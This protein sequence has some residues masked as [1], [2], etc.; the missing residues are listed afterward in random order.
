MNRILTITLLLCICALASPIPLLERTEIG[1]FTLEET[2][3]TKTCQLPALKLKP[4]FVP[5][6]RCRMAIKGKHAAGCNYGVRLSCNGVELT[7]KTASG[8]NRLLERQSRFELKDPQYKGRRFSVFRGSDLLM[9]FAPSTDA[10]DPVTVEGN[11]SWFCLDLSDLNRDVDCNTITFRNIR[12]KDATDRVIIVTDA[13]FGYRKQNMNETDVRIVNYTPSTTFLK[14]ATLRL[15]LY[16]GGAF[17]LSHNDK[18]PAIIIETAIGTTP[19]PAATLTATATPDAKHPAPKITQMGADAFRIQAT[20]GTLKME[21]TLRLLADRL[22]WKEKWSNQ[23]RHIAGVPFRHQCTLASEAPR[24]WLRGEPDTTDQLTLDGNATVFLESRK[25]PGAGAGIVLEDDILR[26]V[27]GA[28][29]EKGIA[30]IYSTTLAVAPGTS[31]SFTYS[32]SPVAEG[33]YWTFINE[34]RDRWGAGKFGIERPVFWA[35]HLRQGDTAAG[36]RRELGHLGNIAVSIPI[37]LPQNW[38]KPLLRSE[39]NVT[40][41]ELMANRKVHFQEFLERTIPKFKRALPNAKILT[42]TH[43][44]MFY[45]YL[46][47]FE[48]S[49]MAADA[50]RTPKGTPYRHDGFESI[51]LRNGVKKGWFIAYLLPRPGG[52][53]FQSHMATTDAVLAAGAD[54]LYCDEFS[55]CNERRSYSRYDYAEWDGFSADLD[56]NGNVIRLKSDCAYTSLQFQNALLHKLTSNGKFFLGNGPTVS[57]DILASAGHRFSEGASSHANM[58]AGHLNHVPL[59]LGNYGDQKSTAGVMAAVREA[60][61]A[62]CVYSPFSTTHFHLQGPDNFVCKL[63]PLTIHRLGPGTIWGKERLITCISGEYTLPP[64]AFAPRLFIY[65]KKGERVDAPAPQGNR[66]TLD[67]PEGGLVIVEWT[68]N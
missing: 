18:G 7:G 49:P 17:A 6:L 28:I 61:L 32:V 16:P 24:V 9:I 33:G 52:Y 26:L 47:E 34:L 58:A 45:A 14:N 56:E 37:W 62:G 63:Y 13:E 50:I 8:H 11:G 2:G 10:A 15:D 57:R 64:E 22:E 48:Q 60:L 53:A 31:R 43:P 35:P 5:V 67:V 39:K 27:A 65:D 4:G 3:D 36:I 1:N 20:F 66:L 21:R 38:D 55:S 51:I 59:V 68:L 23:G 41:S 29:V 40:P 54:G 19:L 25:H 46:P 12:S 30:E 42:M 44:M